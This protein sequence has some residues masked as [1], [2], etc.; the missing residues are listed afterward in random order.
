MIGIMSDWEMIFDGAPV[1]SH[2]AGVTLFVRGAPVTHILLVRSGAVALERLLPSGDPLVLH[3]AGEGDLLA[4]ASLFADAYHCDAVA[5]ANAVVASMPKASFVQRLRK[6]PDVAMALLARASREV[7]S[8]RARVEIL[9]L[10]RLSDRLDAWLELNGPPEVGTWVRVAE[11][12][13]VSPPA[14]Y[15]ELARRKMT[16]RATPY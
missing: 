15:R 9:R 14:L 1:R 6:T 2:E 11:A 7:Q 3:V 5:R 12:I 13:G 10:K 16:D 8:Q 4:D